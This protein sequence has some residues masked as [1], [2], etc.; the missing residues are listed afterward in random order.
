MSKLSMHI[1]RELKI[2]IHEVSNLSTLAEQTIACETKFKVV[3][4]GDWVEHTCFKSEVWTESFKSE[5]WAKRTCF[6]SS[7]EQDFL[8]ILIKSKNIT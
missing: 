5:V 8:R 2:I 6:S 4:E 1:L 7:L 3:I